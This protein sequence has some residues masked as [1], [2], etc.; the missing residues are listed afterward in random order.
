[1][2]MSSKDCLFCRIVAREVP[3]KELYRDEE[4]VAFHDIAPKAPTHILII[5]VKHITSVGELEA[6][7]AGV[8]GKIIIKARD[9]AREQGIDESG[10]RLVS[11]TGPHG[12]QEVP[13]L[14]FHLLGGAP[15]GPMA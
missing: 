4:I 8:V 1:M 14:H 7:D 10:Y 5:P 9:L 12:G 13:H 15:L 2:S 3:A 6:G 11:N